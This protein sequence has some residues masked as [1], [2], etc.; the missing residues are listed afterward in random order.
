EEALL[1]REAL[2][3]EVPLRVP[4]LGGGERPQLQVGGRVPVAPGPLEAID[5]LLGRAGG[6]G[7][8][9]R[10]HGEDEEE[11]SGGGRP[12]ALHARARLAGAGGFRGSRT[13]N[14]LPCPGRLR[15]T[16]RAP[17]GLYLSALSTSLRT[18][19]WRSPRSPWTSRSSSGK[20][21]PSAIPLRSAAARSGSTDASESW[22]RSRVCRCRLRAADSCSS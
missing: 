15:T 4:R 21:K 1:G 13:A 5:R 8:A 7:R 3:D 12:R 2:D 19:W 17:D 14:T 20:S 11:S 22:R 9:R 18:T 6:S 16:I 10:R